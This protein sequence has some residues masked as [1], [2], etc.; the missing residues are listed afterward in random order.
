MALPTLSILLAVGLVWCM[1]CDR[2]RD[3]HP[4]FFRSTLLV[5]LGLGVVA[6][7][8]GWSNWSVNQRGV[9][10]GLTVGFYLCYASWM[11]ERIEQAGIFMRITAVLMLIPAL[12]G[13]LECPSSNALPATPATTTDK[14][15]QPTGVAQDRLPVPT[16]WI[17]PLQ[18]GAEQVSL[19]MILGASMHAM[20]L[21]HYFLQSP[22]MPMA[23]LYD[24]IYRS[25]ATIVF[26]LLMVGIA[27]GQY[28]LVTAPNVQFGVTE[29]VSYGGLRI[30]MGLLGALVLTVMAHQTLK[31]K[32]T[33]AC[34]GI[35]YVVVA[36]VLT[37]EATGQMFHHFA[38]VLR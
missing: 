1:A 11:I 6:L 29:W 4:G 23:R 25:L 8:I 9:V 26:R 10:I 33:Q 35:L 13:Y 20:L 2:Y 5:S 15:T 14:I 17:S 7:L 37:G 30:I 31:Y 21:G 27:F 18:R 12:M 34:T 19:G 22:T 3:L 32:N 38:E 36:F 28:L 16:I 24:A